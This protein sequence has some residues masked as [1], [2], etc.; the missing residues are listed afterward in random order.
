VLDNHH[1]DEGQR[2]A[3]GLPPLPLTAAQVTAL[4]AALATADRRRGRPLVEQLAHRVAPGVDDAAGVKAA[5][6][7]AVARGTAAVPA[8]SAARAVELL[9]TMLGGPN[10]AALVDLLDHPDLGEV[11]AEGLARTL[12]VFDAFHDVVERAHRGGRPAASVLRS[13]AAAGWFTDRPALADA[14]HLTVFKVN[15]ETNT[16]DL[17][18]ATRAWS[19][20]DIPRHALSMLENRTDL[21]DPVGTIGRLKREGRPIVF[22]GDVVGTG[23][24]RKSAVNSLLWHIGDDIAFVPAKRQGGVVIGSRI[25]P[26][27]AS[28]LED[29]GALPLECDVRALAT[30][31]HVVL[32][33]GAGR[34]DAADGRLLAHFAV[35]SDQV[36]DGV[37]AGGRIRFIVGRT[38]TEKARQ[39]LDLGP[40]P[41]VRRPPAPGA[42]SGSAYTLAQKIVGRACGTDGVAPGTYCEPTVST[43]GSQDTTGPMNRNELEELACLGF[44][45]DLVLQTFCHTAAYPKPSDIETQR[46]LPAFM[47]NR[48]GVALRPGD[49]IIHSWL[50]RMLLPD[51]VGTGSDSHTRFP[52]GVSFPAGSGLVAFAAALGVMPVDMPESVLVRFTGSMRPGI[53]LRDLVQA[54]PYAARIQGLLTVGGADKRNAFSGRVLEIEGLEHLTVE[55]A[56]ELSDATA[57]RSAAACAV[58]MSVESV[59][60]YLRSNVVMLRSLI[61]AGYHDARTLA[62]RAQSMERW[63]ADPSLLR[64]DPG[65]R[66]AEVLEI[67]VGAISEPLVACPNDPDDVRPLSEVAG[68]AVDEVFIG[69]CMTNIGHFR[70]AGKVL[71]TAPGP[72]ATRLWIAP[73][74][75]MDEAQLRQEGYYAIFGAA[76]ARTEI[77]GCSLCMGN[78][79]RVAAGATVFSTSTRNFPNRM[80]RDAQVFLG[81]AELAAVV[82]L[83]GGLPSVEQYR[84]QVDLIDTMTAEVYRY[85][86]FDHSPGPL[87]I[88]S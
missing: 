57:E 65:A 13:W 43:V 9:G 53:T 15:G 26:I 6:L 76:G 25:A 85:L 44:S 16:D 69:S 49:G 86:A 29:A 63:L 8:L 27:F 23:S 48:G 58:S 60:D 64:A 32:R 35:P 73:P 62:R 4:V 20:A 67:D 33:P 88:S 28:T 66:Y 77:P 45:A 39:V 79:A 81:S 38:L 68:R 10:V 2:A 1:L 55:Q 31:D 72:V 50:N 11:A 41:V 30:G 14:I 46:T 83:T 71:A 3:L 70:A 74:T 61:D 42:G 19:R 36:L 84:E 17:S 5:F 75:R 40:S 87:A 56:F 59:V 54:I 22:V 12:L 7:A 51:Q 18:P 78:Q 37:R 34:I 21:D 52:L 82:A 47:T 24:S 80:G